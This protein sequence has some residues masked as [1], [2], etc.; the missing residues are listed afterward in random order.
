[1]IPIQSHSLLTVGTEKNLLT[2]RVVCDSQSIE[3]NV[4]ESGRLRS[5]Y[6]YSLV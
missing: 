1:M 2:S 5:V 6:I 4:F 3:A